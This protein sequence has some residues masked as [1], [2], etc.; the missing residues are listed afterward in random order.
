MDVY[1]MF[2]EMLD[3]FVRDLKVI[4]IKLAYVTEEFNKEWLPMRII[5]IIHIKLVTIVTGP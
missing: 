4:I 1:K 2:D 3:R 5:N